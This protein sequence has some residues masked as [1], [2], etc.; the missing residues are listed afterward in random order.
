M[1]D[2]KLLHQETIPVRWGDMDALGHV[3]NTV[4]FRYYETCR[5]SWFDALGAG[6]TQADDEGAVII[7]ASATFLKPIVYPAN[8]I[9]KMYGGNPGNSSFDTRYEICDASDESVLYST[10]EAKVI[11]MDQVANKSKTI[12]DSLRNM[13]S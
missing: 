1:S 9:V 11:W 3:N 6:M 7:N 13:M 12:P 4:Y 10:G 5:V 8:V 2:F